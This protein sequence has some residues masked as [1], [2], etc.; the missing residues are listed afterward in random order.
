MPQRICH[1]CPPSVL[2][3]VGLSCFV[4]F[5][6]GASAD[7][8]VPRGVVRVGQW[9]ESVPAGAAGYGTSCA[10]GN[11]RSLPMLIPRFIKG[12]AGNSDPAF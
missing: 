7:R 1:S 9:T 12:G 8:A 3:T 6:S 2:V 10:L 4:W 11:Q 5:K